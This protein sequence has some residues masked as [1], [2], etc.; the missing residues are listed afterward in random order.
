V[1]LSDIDYELPASAI[2]QTPLEDRASSKLLH[3]DRRT[4]EIHDRVFGDVVDL[5]SPG[6]LLVLNNTRVSARRVLG[7]RPTGA[8]VELLLLRRIGPS[9]YEALAKPGK[10]LR[11]GAIVDLEGG[12]QATVEADIGEGLKLVR[13]LKPIPQ[14]EGGEALGTM[15]LPPYVRAQIPDSSRYQ[16]VYASVDG[17]A[18]APTAGLH[19]TQ[20]ILDA[21]RA[22]GVG[23]AEVTLDVGLDTFRPVHENDPKK[24]QMHGERCT[25]SPRT[26]GAVESCQGR[27]IAVGTTS[28]RTL[29]SFACGNRRVASG[30][31]FSNL[32]ITPGY[33]FKVVDGMFTNFH[34]P[35]T[36]MLL[37]VSAM[38]SVAAMR[39]SYEHALHRGYRFLSFGD[40][41]LII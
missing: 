15:P 30:S 10:R 9:L 27:I 7:R 37:M 17:S 38:A 3:L 34:M 41:M 24:H 20:A 25:L 40:S 29:E 6:D 18:A 13:I 1:Q 28:V 2:A 32:F 14:D 19:F 26:A 16:T 33:E 21:L 4:G 12:T 5:L 11:P 39:R 31:Q 23:I 35:R 36:T 22:K 8:R